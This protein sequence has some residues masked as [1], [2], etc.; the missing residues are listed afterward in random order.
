MMLFFYS[1][2]KNSP[3]WPKRDMSEKK[4]IKIIQSPRFFFLVKTK[5]LPKYNGCQRSHPIIIHIRILILLVKLIFLDCCQIFSGG[6]LEIKI[7]HK[8]QTVKSQILRWR[9]SNNKEITKKQRGSIQRQKNEGNELS[10]KKKKRSWRYR[11]SK[12]IKTKGI[13]Y[14]NK[15]SWGICKHW[16][17]ENWISWGDNKCG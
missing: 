13:D 8:S 11:N 7:G 14:F 1:C 6:F 15:C 4:D 9:N 5:E 17:K 2:M 16:K 3:H 12:L 10:T